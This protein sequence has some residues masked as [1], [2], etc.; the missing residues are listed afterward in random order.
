MRCERL[1]RCRC[2][3]G[4]RRS[5]AR[6]AARRSFEA[7]F[8]LA[9]AARSRA[10][11]REICSRRPLHDISA[12]LL[13]WIDRLRPQPPARSRAMPGERFV[14]GN[15]MKLGAPPSISSGYV[16][17]GPLVDDRH[18]QVDLAADQRQSRYGTA[19]RRAS[20]NRVRPSRAMLSRIP[21]VA[22]TVFILHSRSG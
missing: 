15:P 2:A 20:S 8:P 17:D 11:P 12:A 22:G 10:A 3:C 9:S 7:V 13:G 18:E 19:I 5:S 14:V 6:R 16:H 4:P 21:S 1:R